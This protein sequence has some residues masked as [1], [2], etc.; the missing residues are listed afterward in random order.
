[1]YSFDS[2]DK[3]NCHLFNSLNCLFEDI[4]KKLFILFALLGFI[5][6]HHTKKQFFI[7]TVFVDGGLKKRFYLPYDLLRIF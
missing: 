6:W 2:V 4:V 7:G 1:M 5:V 3:F